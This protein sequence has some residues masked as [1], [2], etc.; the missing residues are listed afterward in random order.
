MGFSPFPAP[1]IEHAKAEDSVRPCGD[2]RM[3]EAPRPESIGIMPAIR[4]EM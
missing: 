2:F 3:N 4:A 1:G